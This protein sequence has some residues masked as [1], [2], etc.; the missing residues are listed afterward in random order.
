MRR[1]VVV[2]NLHSSKLLRL[3]LCID[4]YKVYK[5]II[6]IFQCLFIMDYKTT[7]K[8]KNLILF[9]NDIYIYSL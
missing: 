9:Y 1:N 2:W 3:E 6:T 8:R 4:T 5:N 7:V